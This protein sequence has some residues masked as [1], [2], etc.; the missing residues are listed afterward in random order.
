MCGHLVV[1]RFCVAAFPRGY[2]VDEGPSWCEALIAHFK[3]YEGCSRAVGVSELEQ[4][5]L[6]A[7]RGGYAQDEAR[8]ERVG[9][10]LYRTGGLF[11]ATEHTAIV[12]KRVFVE[13]DGCE[14]KSTPGAKDGE[15]MLKAWRG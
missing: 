6:N 4:I 13:Q 5:P 10:R 11:V 1:A 14:T 15:M 9:A 12:L 7:R 8:R 3:K 2:R